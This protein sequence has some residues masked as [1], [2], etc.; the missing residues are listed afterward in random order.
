MN[1]SR[2]HHCPQSKD[3]GR[4]KGELA[5]RL[6]EGGGEMNE[7]NPGLPFPSFLPSSSSLP[8]FRFWVL[9]PFCL[10]SFNIIWDVLLILC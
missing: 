2:R 6:G 1:N 4:L 5:V 3:A 9:P 8:P 7:M 10:F